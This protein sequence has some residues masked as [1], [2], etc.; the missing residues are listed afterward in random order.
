MRPT[1]HLPDFALAALATG[2]LVMS[3]AWRVPM[4]LWDHLDLIP[5][6]EAHQAGTLLA[7][8][9]FDIYGGHLLLAPYLALLSSAELSGGQTW[10]DC[11][12]SWSLLLTAALL[13]RE[14]IGDSLPLRSG[15][16]AMLSL[17][18]TLLLL[19]P[20]HL[21]NL[22]WGWQVAVFLCL[23]GMIG[24]IHQ[25]SRSTLDWRRNLLALA[26]AG[27]ACLSFATAIAVLPVALLLLGLR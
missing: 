8:S 3:L 27:L 14:F 19:Y 1:R 23:F 22:Q 17:L 9:A 10:L 12:L 2:L 26:A 24:A 25:L 20:G 13:V 16:D 11:L 4:M 7:S 6:L 21:A 15:R 18:P 5:L